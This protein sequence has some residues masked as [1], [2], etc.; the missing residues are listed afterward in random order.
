[1]LE[2]IQVPRGIEPLKKVLTVL[3]I[4][5]SDMAPTLIKIEDKKIE[6]YYKLIFP[7]NYPKKN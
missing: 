2:G 4:N 3:H 5:H 7:F 6:T 1:M